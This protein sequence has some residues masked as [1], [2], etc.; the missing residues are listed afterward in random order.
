S[1][2]QFFGYHPLIAGSKYIDFAATMEESEICFIPK[3]DFTAL[4]YGNRDFSAQFI[5]MLANEVEDKESQ[6]LS[7]AYN[8]I[9]KRVAEALVDL[10]ERTAK[11]ASPISIQR[12]DLASI[13]GTAKD[14]VIRTLT[15]FKTENLISIENGL[16]TILD[17]QTL[18]NMPN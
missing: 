3:D 12:D 8:S 10:E 6:L 13:V 4:L 5:K 7:L 2:G 9:R 1:D 18:K 11:S 17:L 14:A 16:I 15:D